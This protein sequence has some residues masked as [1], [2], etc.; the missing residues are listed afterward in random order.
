MPK[1]RI[2]P[3]AIFC[4]YLAAV[5]FLCLAKPEELPQMPLMFLGLPADKVGHFL[6]FLPFPFLGYIIFEGEGTRWKRT[7]MLLATLCAFGAGMALAIE[8]IQA[9]LGYRAAET[10]DL[11]ADILGLGAGLMLTIIYIMFKRRK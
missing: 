5:I 6:M 8:Q 11:L 4:L 7:S 1:R 9:V 3:V 10:E 2:I